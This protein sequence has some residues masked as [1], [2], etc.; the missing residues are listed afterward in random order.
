VIYILYSSESR[1]AATLKILCIILSLGLILEQ[2][3]RDLSR[4]YRKKSGL[5]CR[6]KTIKAMLADTPLVNTLE[7]E[8]AHQNI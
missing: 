5:N 3:F 4:R 2:L 6:E 1:R 7:N 8:K